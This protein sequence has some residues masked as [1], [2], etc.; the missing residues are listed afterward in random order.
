M[1][2]DEIDEQIA[3]LCRNS[4]T[5]KHEWMPVGIVSGYAHHRVC[6]WCGRVERLREGLHWEVG[7]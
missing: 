2:R 5:A 4:Q 6:Q 7:I 1:E 3:D